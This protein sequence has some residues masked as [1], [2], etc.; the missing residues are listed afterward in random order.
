[1]NERINC[2]QKVEMNLFLCR[3][4]GYPVCLIHDSGPAFFI[5]INCW[6]QEAFVWMPMKQI[7]VM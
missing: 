4:E 3:S 7:T 5:Y 6:V 1:M 2:F